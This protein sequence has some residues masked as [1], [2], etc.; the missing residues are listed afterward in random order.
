MPALY[1]IKKGNEKMSFSVDLYKQTGYNSINVPDSP[2]KI[3]SLTPTPLTATEIIQP[4]RLTQLIVSAS[5]HTVLSADYLRITG[6]GHKVYY[7]VDSYE[8]VA[9]DTACLYITMDYTLTYMAEMGYTSLAQIKFL[10]GMTTRHHIAK[11]DDV[12]GNFCEEDP[13]LIPKKPMD[14]DSSSP[15]F[16]Y[17][18]SSCHK[19]VESRINLLNPGSAALTYT[20]SST[21][22]VVTV[23]NMDYVQTRAYVSIEDPATGVSVTVPNPSAEYYDEGNSTVMNNITQAQNLNLES[24]IL[25]SWMIP[26]GYVYA[27]KSG[28]K[29]DLTA[30]IKK[31]S[32]GLNFVYS[33]VNNKRALYGG[34]TKYIIYSPASGSSAEFQAEDICKDGNS[35]LTAPSVT[36]AVDPRPDGRPYFRF[37][38]YLG[39]T[40]NFWSNA[41]PGQQWANAPLNFTQK[42]GI[43]LDTANFNTAM[44]I[45]K[46]DAANHAALANMRA[47]Q[48]NANIATD[49]AFGSGNPFFNVVGAVGNMLSGDVNGTIGG[50]AGNVLNNYNM[51]QDALQQNTADK[52]ALHM[53]QMAMAQEAQQ[54]AV[55]TQFT[56]PNISFPR[57]NTIRDVLGNGVRVIRVRPANTDIAIFD[58]ILTMFGYR[59]TEPLTGAMFTNRSKFNFIQASGV[60]VEGNAPKWL[61]D[62]VGAE[63][64]VG[65]RFWHV[66]PDSTYY[67]D[68]GNN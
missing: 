23:P 2:A 25:N 63:F 48:A 39:E 19:I 15:L 26:T 41:I 59:I 54:F 51:Q 36:M 38:Q 11:S 4:F 6:D 8:M 52:Q 5:Y 35:T 21:S 67:T 28:G 24:G 47:D 68:G 56:V 10:D 22:E 46:Q 65:K 53:K 49:T 31:A 33:T 16:D 57:S 30:S 17:G 14:M 43:S 27:A 1:F 64:S 50:I 45:S 7:S 37:T 42:A 58:K 60:T 12:F 34:T 3:D 13:M 29:V 18:A 62:G 61:K 44:N 40:G 66:T 9:P 20:D 55:N 32:T